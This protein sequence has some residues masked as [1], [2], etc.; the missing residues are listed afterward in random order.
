VAI[1]AEAGG[2]GVVITDAF[3]AALRTN[4]VSS[5][6]FTHTLSEYNGSGQ[7]VAISTDGTAQV[8]SAFGSTYYGQS[9]TGTLNTNI[10]GVGDARFTYT[11]NS[12][13]PLTSWQTTKTGVPTIITTYNVFAIGWYQAAH[14]LPQQL[15]MAYVDYGRIGFHCCPE[16]RRDGLGMGE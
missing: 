6:I 2:S 12:S 9:G 14:H 16:G 10:S 3:M 13:S 1:R 7:S 8:V 11:T 5:P 4:P 15:L